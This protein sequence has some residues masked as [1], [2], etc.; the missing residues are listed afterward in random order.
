MKSAYILFTGLF[1]VYIG[2]SILGPVLPP[3][4]R[5]LGLSE[6][7]G[8]LVMTFSSIMWVIFSPIW[9]RRSEVWGRKPVF[10]LSLSGYALGVGAFGMVMQ[11]GLD[12]VFASSMVIWL[13]LIASRMI[14]GT[15]FSGSL[16]A[17]QAYVA[18]TT[19]GQTRTNALGVISAASSLG[20]IF[21]PALGGI[22]VGWG[23]VAPIFVSA[24]LPWVGVALVWLF[25]PAIKP[26]V[27]KGETP[28][29]IS[30]V[31][32]RV[33]PTLLVGITVTTILALVNFT[34]GFL[35]QDRLQ[36]SAQGTA[37]AVS[38]ALV[39]SGVAAVIAQMVL[40]R[41]FKWS[42]TTLM[43][44]GLPLLLT[45]AVLLILGRNFWVLT[46]AL[47]F[48]GFGVGLAFPGYRSAITFAVESHEQGAAAGMMSSIGGTGFIFGP[49]LGT[50]LYGINPAF[51]YMFGA[52]VLVV[53]ITILVMKP[54]P[55]LARQAA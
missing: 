9:G 14:V 19:T 48:Q 42:P 35:F 46:L 40:I 7:Q 6:F 45:A 43:R 41:V 17:S 53:G 30:P 55:H 47:V 1:S 10:L 25:L 27:T 50:G 8:G 49:M 34:I 24:L 29:S 16:P 13:L 5:E 38:L 4:V 36:L 32:P 37:Q 54:T 18:D 12:G 2:Q 20:T 22:I 44:I 11:L 51:P 15:L 21:G 31:D 23:L 28:P 52:V 33:W 39:A 26:N 3:L